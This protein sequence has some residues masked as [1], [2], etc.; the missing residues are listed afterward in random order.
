LIR[1]LK[2]A[3]I[4][5]DISKVCPTQD[6]RQCGLLLHFLKP[7]NK[8]FKKK[9]DEDEDDEKQQLEGNDLPCIFC[10]LYL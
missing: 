9:K 6:S 7:L 10:A 8:M 5:R 1:S 2:I 3:L 4:N